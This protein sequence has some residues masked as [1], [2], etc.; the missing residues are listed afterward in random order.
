MLDLEN[1][2]V[3]ATLIPCGPPYT[4][5][6]ICYPCWSCGE[7]FDISGF[8]VSNLVIA[9]A[10]ED[11]TEEKAYLIYV[12]DLPN[13]LLREIQEISPNY[14][15]E[16]TKTTQMDYFVN[17]CPHCGMVTGDWFLWEKA[18]GLDVETLPAGT[19]LKFDKP[20]EVE[21]SFGVRD[22]LP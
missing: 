7:K 18:F 15:K 21:A 8:V 3:E 4:I 17:V 9:D 19:V 14:R 13:E 10:L 6:S 11:I 22:A 5:I 16:F 20:M 2:P 12:K 1:S